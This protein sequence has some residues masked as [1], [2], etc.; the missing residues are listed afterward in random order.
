MDDEELA[1]LAR[2]AALERINAAIDSELP[3]V[4]S[5]VD[6]MLARQRADE[7]RLAEKKKTCKTLKSSSEVVVSPRL[8]SRG[9]TPEV[10]AEAAA[11]ISRARESS[12]REQLEASLSRE[13]DLEERISTAEAA[14]AKAAAE[15]KSLRREVANLRAAVDKESK[16]RTE[17]QAELNAAKRDAAAAERVAREKQREAA[18]IGNEH[19]AGD[20]RLARAVEEAD[21]LKASLARARS[22]AR[23]AADDRRKEKAALEA[24]IKKLERQKSELHA[25]FRKQLKLIDILKRQKIHMEAARLLAFTEEEFMKIVSWVPP[26]SS[27]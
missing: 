13:R 24:S 2:E 23:D 9:S 25:A 6:S 7:V 18:Q 15:T 1:L 5:D 22:D 27:S 21:K 19:R 14:S 8:P 17:A 11:R 20:V 26:E 4:V 12:L 10:G 16:A 3:G